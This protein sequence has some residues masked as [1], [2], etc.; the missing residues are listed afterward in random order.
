MINI[1][2]ELIKDFQVPV[3]NKFRERATAR[4]WTDRPAPSLLRELY[5]GVLG[6]ARMRAINQALAKSKAAPAPGC[7]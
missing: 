7:R 6:V 4:I 1:S 3:R 5:D 2:I